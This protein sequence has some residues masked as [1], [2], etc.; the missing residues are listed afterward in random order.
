LQ[1]DEFLRKMK[2]NQ[3]RRRRNFDGSIDVEK[4]VT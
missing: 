3:R 1:V 4:H 2:E